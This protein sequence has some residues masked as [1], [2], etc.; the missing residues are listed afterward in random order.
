MS[1]RV[2]YSNPASSYDGKTINFTEIWRAP[3][4]PFNIQTVLPGKANQQPGSDLAVAV[5]SDY[6]RLFYQDRARDI[7]V[8]ENITGWTGKV[9]TGLL[10]WYI[11]Y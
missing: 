10:F 3:R 2:Q 1:I 11:H 4:S 6:L 8:W 7:K 9:S 5:R